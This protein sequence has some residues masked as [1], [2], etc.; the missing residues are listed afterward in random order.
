MNALADESSKGEDVYKRQPRRMPCIS[1]VRSW[2]TSSLAALISKSTVWLTGTRAAPLLLGRRNR[3]LSKP[4]RLKVAVT[5]RPV[6][7]TH[8]GGFG[9]KGV[10]APVFAESELDATVATWKFKG[11]SHKISAREAN[12]SQYSLDSVKDEDEMCIRD[13]LFADHAH[14][15]R[16][17]ARARQGDSRSRRPY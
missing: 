4:F 5:L 11:A 15:R 12:E 16:G 13:R 3:P 17:R 8:L 6:S 9:S 14:A 2:I 1:H 10:S 7:Y